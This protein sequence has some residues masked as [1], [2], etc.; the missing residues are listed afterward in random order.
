MPLSLLNLGV[1]LSLCGIDANRGVV[2]Y[3]YCGMSQYAQAPSGYSD[4][5]RG[6]FQYWHSA[7]VVVGHFSQFEV[8]SFT[9]HIR[10]QKR[11]HVPLVADENI[12]TSEGFSEIPEMLLH[13]IV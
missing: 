7:T 3:P 8:M 12:F 10:P 13:S 9:R 2:G 6:S 11:I 5:L 4:A 1:W